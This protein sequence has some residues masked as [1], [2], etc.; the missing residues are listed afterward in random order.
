MG[1]ALA[2]CR[3][4]TGAAV[5]RVA[6]Q[7]G[8]R[9][10]AAGVP[11]AS[12]HGAALAE[13]G[14]EE[15]LA[16]LIPL[17]GTDPVRAEIVVGFVVEHVYLHRNA[18]TIQNAIRQIQRIVG[19]LKAYSHLDQQAGLVSS[20]LH[21]GI[22]TTLILLDYALRGIRV[23][24]VYGTLPLVPVFVDELNQVW[25]NLIQ[26]AAQAL[27][28]RTPAGSITIQTSAEADGAIVRVI[29]DGAGISDE[30]RELIFEPFFTTK[31]KGE[32]TGLGLGIVRKIVDKH[33]GRVTCTSIPGRTCFEVWL[34]LAPPPIGLASEAPAGTPASP[35]AGPATTPADPGPD[36]S[37]GQGEAAGS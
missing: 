13:L 26:N 25:T 31:G 7:L 21:E 4:P 24:R 30:V 28:N 29:D 6:R 22:E 19:A 3:L 11:G 36:S 5:R 1:P 35:P 23:T 27:A 33:R 20:D 12:A 9:L 8:E 18:M 17:L 15:D 14:V 32:G 37:R 2:A 16:A 10:E 34:P